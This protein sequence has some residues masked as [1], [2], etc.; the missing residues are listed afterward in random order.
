ML[1][2]AA[3]RSHHPP[4]PPSPLTLR[5]LVGQLACSLLLSKRGQ[6]LRRALCIRPACPWR[7]PLGCRSRA[8][9]ARLGRLLLGCRSRARHTRHARLRHLLPSCRAFH[10]RLLLSCLWLGSSM[11]HSCQVQLK[12]LCSHR[13]VAVHRLAVAAMPPR[14]RRRSA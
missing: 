1:S 10:T 8:R 14:W 3:Q 2:I 13:V 7:L 6:L 4:A 12:V 9:H 5:K 11:Q